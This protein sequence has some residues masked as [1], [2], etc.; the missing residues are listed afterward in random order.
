MCKSLPENDNRAPSE[1]FKNM[2]GTFSRERRYFGQSFSDGNNLLRINT[3]ILIWDLSNAI[4]GKS[5]KES[6]EGSNNSV[7]DGEQFIKCNLDVSHSC[8]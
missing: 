5:L 4:F 1:P 2:T 6:L 3:D 8:S 7:T